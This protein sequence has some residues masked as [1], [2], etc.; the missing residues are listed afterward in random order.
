[1]IILGLTGSIGM[2]K[3]T[4]A[5]NFRCLGIPVHDADRTV[6]SLMARGGEAVGILQKM[7]PAAVH[8]GV[9]DRGAI[10]TEVFA[11]ADALARIEAAL[12]PLVRQ[13][14]RVFLSQCARQGR[15]LVVLDVP[16][17]FETGGEG[18]CDAVVTVSA[19][20]FVQRQRVL[21]RPG[22]T[23][24]RLETILARQTPDGEKQKRS[25]FVVY[26]GLGRHY[27]LRQIQKIVRLT[28][29]WQ[30]RRWPPRAMGRI[31]TGGKAVA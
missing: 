16:L 1:M 12:H 22:M 25:D 11:D 20:A 15:A 17:L 8:K 2:G 19:P 18:R 21:R 29:N 14:E 4:A 24:E 5:A 23:P 30:G 3:S 31:V 28:R 9:V 26:S 6:H 10:A 27:S 13:R 7:F